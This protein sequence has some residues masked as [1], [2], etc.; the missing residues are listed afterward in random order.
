MV[1]IEN[2]KIKNNIRGIDVEFFS[3]KN[4]ERKEINL[5]ISRSEMPIKGDEILIENLDGTHSVDIANK[6]L[7]NKDVYVESTRMVFKVILK[8][9]EIP[10]NI[11]NDYEVQNKKLFIECQ[12]NREIKSPN[13]NVFEVDKMA[14]EIKKPI[15]IHV[16]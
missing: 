5:I 7:S 9:E 8:D 13:A 10:E 6:N 15:Q 16:F 14:F 4:D 11:K 1:K 3:F 2:P 12:S